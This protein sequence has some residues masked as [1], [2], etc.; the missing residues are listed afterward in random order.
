MPGVVSIKKRKYRVVAGMVLISFLST[1]ILA[2]VEASSNHVR[3]TGIS[4]RKGYSD[5]TPDVTV[6]GKD[7]PDEDESAGHEM[8]KS[9]LLSMFRSALLPG[10]GQY[11]TGHPYRGGIVFTLEG[12]LV[13]FSWLENRKANWYWETYQRT[14]DPLYLDKYDRHFRKGRNYMSLAIAGFLLNIADA[15][16]SAHLY[17]FEGKVSIDDEK[18]QVDLSMTWKFH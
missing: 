6:Q 5:A 16:V 9:P 3:I 14:G 8:E 11:Y 15:Y 10:W 17:G 2:G 18:E 1:T 4:M 13:T 7:L 12:F